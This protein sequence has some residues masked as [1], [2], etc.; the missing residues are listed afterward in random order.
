MFL[1]RSIPWGARI[2]AT[3]VAAVSSLCPAA[4]W[5][6]TPAA[7]PAGPAF[8]RAWIQVPDNMAAAA[9]GSDL[10]R[11]SVMLTLPPIEG[12]VKVYVNG[13]LIADLP[14]G[15]PDAPARIK[16]P[17]GSLTKDVFNAVVLR[18]E[19]PHAGR[20]L[21]A[22]PTLSGYFDELRMTRPWEWT[23]DQPVETD[24]RPVAGEPA[25]SV[26]R[27]ADFRP[28]TSVLQPAAEPVRGRQV[29]PA[30]ALALLETDYD[31]IVEELLHEPEV[32][33]PTHISFDERG[34][35]WVAQYRQYPF[36]A[37]VHMISR[38]MY[39]RSKYDRVP[40]A[41]PHHSPGADVISIHEDR[42]G[43]GRYDSHRN[44]L[45]G[46]NMANAALRGHGGIWVMHTPYLLFYP[47][48]DGD[49]IPD[50]EPEVRLQGFGLEDTHS[51]ANGLAWG[52]DGWLYGAQG[53]TTTSR[54]TRPGID[55]PDFPGIY[56]EGCMVWRYH[57]E[58]RIYEIFADGSGNTFG[59]SFDAE[60][61]LFT[62]HNGGDTRGWHHIPDG[63]YLK[64]GKDPG[65]FGPPPNP[66]AFGELPMMRS[67]HPVPR[68]SH[69][70]LVVDA[71]ALPERL[72]GRFLAVDPLHHNLVAAERIRAGST[73][74]ST[75]LG[76]PLRTGDRTFRPVYLTHAPDGSIVIADFREEYIAHGQNYQSQID[77]DSGRIYRLRGR[78]IPR[79][80]DTDLSAKS[81]AGLVAML[82]H[83]GLWQRQTAVRLL[84][85]RNDASVV[86]DLLRLLEEPETH[87]ALEALW[88]LH[89]MGKLDPLTALRALEH[90]AAP[91]RA[92]VIRLTGDSRSLPEPF[93]ERL[94]QLAATEP[95][96]EV[97]CQ[98]ISTARRLPAPLALA[99]ARAVALRPDDT[100]DAFLP[101]MTWFVIE[102][103]C[104]ESRDAVLNLFAD[105][106]FREAP[107]VREHL[108]SR[109]MRRFAAS[110]TRQE[111]L[112]C[113]RLLNIA[114]DDPARDRLLAGFEQAFA[115]R[116]LPPMP[117]EL[118]AALA[119]AGRL[120]LSLRVRQGDTAAVAEALARIPDASVPVEERISLVR[121]LGETASADALPLL[122]T[123]ATGDGPDDLRI[124]A[125]TAL[126][127]HGAP[128]VGG[129]IAAAWP[130]LPAAVRPAALNLLASR[131]EWAASLVQAV[132]EKTIP[133][134]LITPDILTRIRRYRDQNLQNLVNRHLPPPPPPAPRAEIQPRIARVKEVL[135]AKPG[136][137]YRGE[138]LFDTHCGTC[139][140][141]FFKGGSI[142][143]DLTSYQR[144]DL[145]TML[146]S[147]LDPDAEIREGYENHVVTTH[148]GRTLGGFLA[149]E[150]AE[151][152]VLRG[153]DGADIV[154]RR[155][156]VASVEPAGRSLMPAFLLDSLTDD[157]IRDLFA[158]LRQSQ[159]ITR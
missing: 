14:E 126:Q 49:D 26:Y 77:P 58:S 46:L 52:P 154:L 131:G 99:I 123:L 65:K 104:A 28:A 101:L 106:S 115:G 128:E 60:G 152:I 11:E 159:P 55:P 95:D 96:A 44:V 119:G 97:R 37:G 62:G 114:S 27:Q 69:M 20:E 76:F 147:I 15:S 56:V 133:A 155:S 83:D 25:A 23:R 81:S 82:R 139:H 144:D 145:G 72:Q 4:D 16:V 66:Y 12:G 134:A 85:E 1:F 42:D 34:R 90:P 103:H 146:V 47:D 73:F 71:P 48:A 35:M 2:A 33:Q 57:P 59:I 67:T 43:D 51:V 38:D 110:G 61:R 29:P 135:A 102:S 74:E 17:A 138:P 109:V 78:D 116:A 68:F 107:L 124:A 5:T 98:M 136:D 24:F 121:V 158:Y 150:D 112:A 89:Q 94:L 84:G 31:L 9:E 64:Q 137:P 86:P 79:A 54:V 118:T 32:A 10:F 156:E 105:G 40:P 3:G 129:R 122:L 100:A 141:L 143:P 88:A 30:E 22:P 8:H 93:A 120:S 151:T 6:T 142:G 53:S 18:L 148:D 50:R 36:P 7:G 39:Y 75:D 125:C 63:L 70:T 45:T 92:W 153:F 130:S 127:R 19:G 108:L 80:T 157:Q 21:P 41:P 87:P 132:A 140:R 149:D 91:V 111:L 117:D 13:R 113:A